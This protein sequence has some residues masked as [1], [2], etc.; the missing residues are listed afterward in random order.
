MSHYLN[1]YIYISKCKYISLGII[2]V[3]FYLYLF[4][5]SEMYHVHHVH[6]VQ[7]KFLAAEIS[8]HVSSFRFPPCLLV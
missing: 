6:H 7:C 3:C 5:F 1:I 8:G 2:I 4:E